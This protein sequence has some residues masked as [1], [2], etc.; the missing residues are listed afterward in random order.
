MPVLPETAPLFGTVLLLLGLAAATP[1]P[2]PESAADLAE[3]AV[4]ATLT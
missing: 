2:A 4:R 1:E 3:I